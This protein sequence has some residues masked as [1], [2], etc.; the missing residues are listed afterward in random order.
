[1]SWPARLRGWLRRSPH[2]RRASLAARYL[3]GEGIEIGALQNPLPLPPGARVTY[4]DR[5][6][7]ADLREQYPELEG[8]DLIEPDV[9]DDGER[10]KKFAADSLDFVVAN[11]F[12]EHCQDPIGAIQNFLRVL[13][14]G[15]VA[16][17]AVPEMRFTF[18]RAREV[19]TMEHLLRDHRE[20]PE[21]SRREHFEQ[22]VRLVHKVDDEA[23]AQNRI[24]HFIATDYS[25]HFH[26]WTEAS[27]REFFAALRGDLGFPFAIDYFARHGEE[28][29]AVLR[30]TA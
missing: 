7:V 4:V 21:G 20:G 27:L 11:H 3:R 1:M 25:I 2:A 12:L 5:M 22:W 23:W 10:L 19:T 17:V 29:V 16:L 8:R 24:E 30:K 18:D 26:V 15:G 14:P 9:L 28:C 13:R 6:T